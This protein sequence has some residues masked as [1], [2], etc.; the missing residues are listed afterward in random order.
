[1]MFGATHRD[2]VGADEADSGKER[3]I[4]KTNNQK[5]RKKRKTKYAEI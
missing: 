3:E 4:T 5:G 2:T 1:M